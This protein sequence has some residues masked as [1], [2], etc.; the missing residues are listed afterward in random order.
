ME[1][2]GLPSRTVLE[3]STRKKLFFDSEGNPKIF[4]NS[5]GKTRIPGRKSLKELMKGA[6]SSFLNLVYSCLEWD[7]SKRMTPEE[8]LNHE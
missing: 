2:L 7:P 8:A 3:K 4:P 5:R 1:V 6:D